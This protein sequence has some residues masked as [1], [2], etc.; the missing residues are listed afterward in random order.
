MAEGEE[1]VDAPESAP[2]DPEPSKEEEKTASAGEEAAV[3]QA[4]S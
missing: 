1:K 2:K 4:S 3:E